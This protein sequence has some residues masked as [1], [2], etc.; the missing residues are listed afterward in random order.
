MQ[1]ISHLS[2][3]LF[4]L[5]LSWIVISSAHADAAA[6]NSNLVIN[7]NFEQMTKGAPDDWQILDGTFGSTASFPAEKGKGNVAR[8][9]ILQSGKKG[10]YLAQWVNL[11]PNQN[12]RLSMQAMMTEGKLTFAVGN[13]GLNVR[14][15]GESR[16]ELPMSPL[17]WDESWQNS[18][19]FVPGQ[20]REASFDFN[21]KD[22][23]RVL[24]SLGGFFAAGSYFFDDVKLVKLPSSK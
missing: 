12:Y 1:R 22:V 7:G 23:K 9:D 21:S 17:F 6:N 19:P 20:W 4:L 18:I 24:V 16:E 15:F 8:V 14:M 2:K 5:F 3:V 11:E 13:T 10:A